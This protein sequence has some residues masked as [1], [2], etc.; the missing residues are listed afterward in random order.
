MAIDKYKFN[1]LIN[2]NVEQV[3]QTAAMIC[4]NGESTKQMMQERV[5]CQRQHAAGF[6]V[7]SHLQATERSPLHK[8]SCYVKTGRCRDVK[9][10]LIVDRGRI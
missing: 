8:S 1:K 10:E 6:H 7:D 5:K 3:G 4:G 9:A 2:A